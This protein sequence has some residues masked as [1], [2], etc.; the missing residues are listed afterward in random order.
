M[1]CRRWVVAPVLLTGLG[2]VNVAGAAP[3]PRSRAWEE[4]EFPFAAPWGDVRMAP[5]R[6]PAG[7]GT[8][9]AAP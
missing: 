6:G 5:A 1:I 3:P 8:S 2:P 4:T 9:P 7:R